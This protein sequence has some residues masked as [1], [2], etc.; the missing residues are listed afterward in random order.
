MLRYHSLL[1]ICN[2]CPWGKNN[3]EM[4]RTCSIV[5]SLKKQ[6]DVSCWMIL[7]CYIYF[8]LMWLSV[9]F[10]GSTIHKIYNMSDSFMRKGWCGK[11]RK[12]PKERTVTKTMYKGGRRSVFMCV[13]WSEGLWWQVFRSKRICFFKRRSEQVPRWLVCSAMTGYM[14]VWWYG[15]SHTNRQLGLLPIPP[16]RSHEPN[17]TIQRS[18]TFINTYGHM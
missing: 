1:T 6:S 4:Y 2:R 5:H 15:I 13:R 14:A 9:I 7:Y 10:N 8:S 16:L 11:I 12:H 17:Y 3:N 18:Q